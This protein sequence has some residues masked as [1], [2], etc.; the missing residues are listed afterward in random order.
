MT[1]PPALPKSPPTI[2]RETPPNLSATMGSSTAGTGLFFV[3]VGLSMLGSMLGVVVVCGVM[4]F[5]FAGRSTSSNE[6]SDP[7]A[8]VV[9]ESDEGSSTD[10]A[11]TPL[12][13]AG[14]GIDPESSGDP[15]VA[16]LDGDNRQP[17]SA[18]SEIDSGNT[19]EEG[20]SSGE[21]ESAGSLS[22]TSPDNTESSSERPLDD[23]RSHQKLLPIVGGAVTDG[24]IALCKVGVSDPKQCAL[25]L[26]DADF[27]DPAGT[28]LELKRRDEDEAAQWDVLQKVTNGIGRNETLGAFELK[29]ET[30]SFR[31]R[32]GVSRSYLPFCRLRL[33]AT[34]QSGEDS[35]VC[36]LWKPLRAAAVKLSFQTTSGIV[37]LV[38]D[39]MP[40]P[41]VDCLGL[42]VRLDAFP[43]TDFPE[44]KVLKPGQPA[45]IVVIDPET[46]GDLLTTKLEYRVDRGRPHLTYAH[47]AAILKVSVRGNQVKSERVSKP[48]ASKHLGKLKSDAERAHKNTERTLDRELDRLSGGAAVRQN[49]AAQRQQKK[50]EEFCDGLEDALLELEDQETWIDTAAQVCSEIEADGKIHLRLFRT[51]NDGDDVDILVT[52]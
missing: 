12:G 40:L 9:A 10:P 27:S 20:G 6:F 23:V 7:F 11:A 13:N 24:S 26:I 8:D 37:A 5:G 34:D 48:F 19:A 46:G 32:S 41:P 16:M 31:W 29:G 1:G 25:Q 2:P 45:E 49:P 52:Q 21:T 3:P 4:V 14:E 47:V 39:E 38:P 35:E 22:Q 44:A 43:E 36:T 50:L 51:T 28:I 17:S 42:E 15:E 33:T 18:P 30:L